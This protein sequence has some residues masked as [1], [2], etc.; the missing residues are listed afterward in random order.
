MILNKFAGD[1]NI[2][3][4]FVDHF[5]ALILNQTVW[6]ILF[7]SHSDANSLAN[8]SNHARPSSR[9]NSQDTFGIKE[10]KQTLKA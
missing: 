4:T 2:I 10:T 1:I 6:C 3:P 5:D 7:H 9:G 8:I